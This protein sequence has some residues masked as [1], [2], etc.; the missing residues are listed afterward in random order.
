MLLR[1]SIGLVRGFGG[2]P[3]LSKSSYRLWEYG[4]IAHIHECVQMILSGVA[5]DN[6]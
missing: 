4:Q 5:R 3:D 1:C 2:R 6:L